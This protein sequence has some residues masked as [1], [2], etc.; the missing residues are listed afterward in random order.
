V[1]HGEHRQQLT[2]EQLTDD[3]LWAVPLTNS[4]T[5]YVS[6]FSSPAFLESHDTTS[7]VASEP[8]WPLACPLLP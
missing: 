4:V 6:P 5:E 7:C 2:G 8:L 3:C 1:G